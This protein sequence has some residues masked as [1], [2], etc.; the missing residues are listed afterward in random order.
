MS[1]EVRA[2]HI[3]KTLNTTVAL[4]D[5]STVFEAGIVHGVVGPNGAGKTTL[6][7]LIKG[8]L[9][10]DKGTFRF[11][12]RD[13]ACPAQEAI[14]RTGYFPQEPSLYP[15]LSVWEHLEFF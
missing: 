5:V 1:I 2:E 6:L 3:S 4:T 14:S 12:Y 13:K 11:T 8:L 10:P 9:K 7:R 15:D